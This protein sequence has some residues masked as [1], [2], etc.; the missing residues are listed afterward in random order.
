VAECLEAAE[1]KVKW[2]MIAIACLHN[3][4]INK[5]IRLGIAKFRSAMETVPHL[6]VLNKS[7]TAMHLSSLHKNA[8][9]LEHEKMVDVFKDQWL[10]NLEHLAR[11]IGSLK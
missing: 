4:C 3:F 9:Y 11:K 2:L 5:Q 10:E 1:G 6:F 8:A 7:F